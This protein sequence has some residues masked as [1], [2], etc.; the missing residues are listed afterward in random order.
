MANTACSIRTGM[1]D[2]NTSMITM[3][4]LMMCLAYASGMWNIAE[5]WKVGFYLMLKFFQPCQNILH[6][7]NF[8]RFFSNVEIEIVLVFSSFPLKWLRASALN[9]ELLCSLDYFHYSWPPLYTL[10]E[11][12][13]LFVGNASINDAPSYDVI[14]RGLIYDVIIC[15]NDLCVTST[16]AIWS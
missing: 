11:V 2:I 4:V 9:F 16:S 15:G 3:T 14:A 8:W 7:F 12:M 13:A 10:Y 6:F 5:K 1:A